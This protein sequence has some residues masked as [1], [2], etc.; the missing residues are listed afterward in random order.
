MEEKPTKI[1]LTGM[2]TKDEYDRVKARAKFHGMHVGRFVDALT[3]IDIRYNIL[4]AFAE[5][6]RVVRQRRNRR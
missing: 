6:A 3:T 4:K 1:R 5:G 2:M